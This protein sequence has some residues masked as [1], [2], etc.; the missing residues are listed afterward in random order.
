MQGLQKSGWRVQ[1]VP[2]G[3]ERTTAAYRFNE[4]RFAT[5]EDRAAAIELAR[6][7]QSSNLVANQVNAVQLQRAQRQAPQPGSPGGARRL[8]V[9]ISR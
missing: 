7:V 5:P 3:G 2:E 9:W 6:E 1:G 4:V 8:E